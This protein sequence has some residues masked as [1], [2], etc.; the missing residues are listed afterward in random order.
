MNH[1]RDRRNQASPGDRLGCLYSTRW[2]GNNQVSPGDK[3]AWPLVKCG[4]GVFLEQVVVLGL[5]SPDS[6]EKHAYPLVKHAF[7]VIKQA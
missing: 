1:L 2:A 4:F 6:G 7:S 3:Q 5:L